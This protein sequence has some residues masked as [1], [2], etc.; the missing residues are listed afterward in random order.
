MFSSVPTR[1]FHTSQADVQTISWPEIVRRIG[2]I[3]D[4]NPNIALSSGS[5]G[6]SDSVTA[7][8]DAHDIANRIMRQ[9]NYLIAL[10][11]KELLDLSV[12]MPAIVERFLGSREDGRGKT[13]TRALEWNLR[14]CLMGHLFDP[15]GKVRRKFLDQRNKEELVI[16]WVETM[17][18]LT[19]GLR[20]NLTLFRLRRRFLFMGIL[21]AIFAPFLVIYLIMYSFF[22]YFE[23]GPKNRRLLKENYR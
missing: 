7:P 10:F 4:S 3:R 19:N 12:P 5:A 16:E 6:P 22:R 11:N 21:N 1:P 15:Y 2:A 8:L 9:E 23:V 17:L 13:L 20:V 14:F 18:V